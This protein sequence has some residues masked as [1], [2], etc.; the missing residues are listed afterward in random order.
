MF[1][2]KHPPRTPPQKLSYG[3]CEGRLVKEGVQGSGPK[4]PLPAFAMRHRFENNCRDVR[5]AL[6]FRGIQVGILLW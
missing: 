1:L 2:Q 5:T 3:W 4:S 6:E